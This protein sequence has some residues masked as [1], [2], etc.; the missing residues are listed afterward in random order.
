MCAI[1][2]TFFQRTKMQKISDN[3]IRK[4]IY[5]FFCEFCR[6]C[7]LPWP[8][9]LCFPKGKPRFEPRSQQNLALKSLDWF[10]KELNGVYRMIEQFNR[11]CRILSFVGKK[12]RQFAIDRFKD[13]SHHHHQPHKKAAEAVAITTDCLA[14]SV[15]VRRPPFFSPLASLANLSTWVFTS[16]LW[17]I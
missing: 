10:Q 5:T 12:G 17:S 13:F 7:I 3:L 14:G 11:R 1:C 16:R 8:V 4:C 9:F 6:F 2:Y 15:M